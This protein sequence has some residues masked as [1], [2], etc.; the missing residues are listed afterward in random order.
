MIFFVYLNEKPLNSF[1]VVR[2][3]PGGDD[4][5][6]NIIIFSFLF[7]IYVEFIFLGVGYLN[8]GKKKIRASRLE[9]SRN[10]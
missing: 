9:K 10:I 1:D 6:R 4:S 8:D 2:G 5:S 3:G 7:W